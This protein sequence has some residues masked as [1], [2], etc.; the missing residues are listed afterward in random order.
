MSSTT[1]SSNKKV[2]SIDELTGK[3]LTRLKKK[4]EEKEKK[5]P[6]STLTDCPACAVK[7]LAQFYWGIQNLNA[8]GVPVSLL[9]NNAELDRVHQVDN[10]LRQ[11][12]PGADT[13]AGNAQ[14]DPEEMQTRLLTACLE[15]VNYHLN[16]NTD[17]RARY[18]A[19]FI[20]QQECFWNCPCGS[21]QVPLN[22]PAPD[23]IGFNNIAILSN[24]TP[25]S[26]EEAMRREFEPTP[27]NTFQCNSC[28]STQQRTQSTRIEGSPEYLRIK[29]SIVNSDGTPNLNPVNL[30]EV[31]NLSEYQAVGDGPPLLMYRLS[32]V[33]AHGGTH[34][35]GHWV[36]SVRGPQN[37]FYINDHLV[38]QRSLLELRTNPQ[39]YGG[40]EM[41]A[42]VLMYKRFE[43]KL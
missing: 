37:V 27:L 19:L 41:T 18:E 1:I 26:L 12:T 5:N 23:S 42:V 2:S 16:E 29:L 11:F 32:S 40:T 30:P 3:S 9:F 43:K 20:L 15:S 34:N 31:L 36:A 33:L 6:G 21:Q 24:G 25:D 10:M 8:D 4:L 7:A 22:N 39:V 35:A 17:W 13:G 38:G 28:N 14:E